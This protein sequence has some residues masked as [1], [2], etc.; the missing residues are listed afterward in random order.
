VGTNARAAPQIPDYELIRV[1]G[2]GSFGEVW[3]A[4]GLT[5]I[6][7]AI[8]IIRRDRF[9]DAAPFERE[10]RGLKEFAAI[11]LG[12]ATQLALLHVGRNDE[13][14]FFYYVMELAD[15]A[16][17]RAA[18]E[19]AHYVPLTLGEVRER[20]GR[21]PADECMRIGVALASGLAALHRRGVV[22]RDIKPTNVILVQ[23]VPKLADIGL[24]SPTDAARTFVGTEGF[25]PPEGP[26]SPRADVFALGKLLYEL[27]TG[28]DR[29]DFPQLPPEINRWPDSCAFLRLND[30]ILRA[31]DPLP[32]KR[33]L[34]AT[35]LLA[36][37][38]ILQAGR[39]VPRFRWA[40]KA[41]LGVAIVALGAA[42]STLWLRHNSGVAASDGAPRHES[43]AAAE[44]A[45]HAIAVLPFVNLSDE[46]AQEYFSDGISEELLTVLQKIPG[47]R[48]SART[49]A[50]S[51]KGRNVLADE[52]GRVLGVGYLVE[53]SVRK[54]GAQVRVTARLSRAA[55]GDQLWS[56]SYTRNLDDVFSLQAELA[57]TIVEHLRGR[58]DRELS[59]Q[60]HEAQRG[61][62]RDAEAHRLYLQGRFL[63]NQFTEQNLAAA[64]RCFEQA[65]QIDPNYA[66]ALAALASTYA[67]QQNYA[68]NTRPGRELVVEARRAAERALQIEPAL[69]EAYTALIEVH[70]GDDLDWRAMTVAAQRALELAPSDPVNICNVARLALWQGRA[71]EAIAHAERALM[72]DPLNADVRRTLSQTYFAAGR[73]AEGE[74]ENRRLRE[75]NPDAIGLYADLANACLR[76]HR[77]AEALAAA[78]KE[79]AD[80][81]RLTLSALAQWSL[82]AHDA[83]VALR[84][85]LIRRYPDV[86]AYQIGVVFAYQ[87]DAN[88]AFSWL[89]RA[90][91]Q[92]DP[93]LASML[94]LKTVFENLHGD[95]RWPA[96]LQRVGLADAA[97]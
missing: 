32:E 61:G 94:C 43:S 13:A 91:V 52:I 63:N 62:T 20:R 18:I 12:E 81:L 69:P 87:G 10:F 23:G 95:P 41:L 79:K 72:L 26:G 74:M 25:V 48:V 49:S 16:D 53:G 90:Y 40:K 21:L 29:R 30:V 77:F 86:C 84:D 78:A 76:E 6:Y 92:R 35:A 58:L 64:A 15:A 97:R 47:L 9:A 3:L 34:D 42:V 1:V 46:A 7:R 71:A 45:A 89:E 24:V 83:S 82:G 36:D 60:V 28:L 80:Y 73:F 50:F 57:Q 75:S 11:S 22:H 85:E 39:A 37:L 27:A 19:P 59:S 51:F 5:G 33:Y 56:E 96:F 88:R 4:R 66:L 70:L 54:T 14:G 68:L 67:K 38:Q 2:H 65:L 17:G 93:G 55:T 31:C 8:K 44:L